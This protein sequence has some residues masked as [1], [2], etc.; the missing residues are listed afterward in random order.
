MFGK[1][2]DF[3]CESLSNIVNQKGSSCSIGRGGSGGRD[4]PQV[5][6]IPIL[7]PQKSLLQQRQLD[8]TALYPAVYLRSESFFSL[9]TCGGVFATA[10]GALHPT[11]NAGAG[12]GEEGWDK[13][14]GRR[15]SS[16]G[17]QATGMQP[18]EPMLRWQPSV[19]EIWGRPDF[20]YLPPPQTPITVYSGCQPL[21]PTP[22][23]E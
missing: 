3:V 16:D 22:G 18:P 2:R 13:Y 7:T 6:T 19:C 4:Q 10:G 12:R 8:S 1:E 21:S 15:V 17:A 23:I 20:S 5:S 9:H 14:Q 11:A